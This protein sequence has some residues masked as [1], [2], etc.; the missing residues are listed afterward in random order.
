MNAIADHVTTKIDANSD[1]L[2]YARDLGLVRVGAEGVEIA[3]PIYR[4]VLIRHLAYTHQLSLPAPWWPWRTPEGRL[5]GRDPAP[6]QREVQ[7]SDRRHTLRLLI[8]QIARTGNR[9]TPVGTSASDRYLD[10]PVDIQTDML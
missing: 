4:E 9:V 5:N 1:D 6:G 7:T 8:S 3:S 10:K 2:S